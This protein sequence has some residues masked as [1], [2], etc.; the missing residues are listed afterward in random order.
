MQVKMLGYMVFC[1][2]LSCTTDD[3]KLSQLY[4]ILFQHKHKDEWISNLLEFAF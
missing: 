3:Q 2:Q 4:M 1:K